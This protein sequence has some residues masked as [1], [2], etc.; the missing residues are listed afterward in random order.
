LA[1]FRSGVG[2]YVAALVGGLAARGHAVTVVVPEG[3]E[4]DVPGVAVRTVARSAID[5]TPRGK[6]SI[7]RAFAAFVR[8]RAGEFDVAHFADAREA[9]ALGRPSLPVTAAVHDT[10]ALDWDR[11][12][13]P[14]HLFAD[15]TAR[16]LYFRAL[17]AVER[18]TYRRFDLVAANS[19]HVARAL[20]QGYGLSAG[21]VRVV[22]LGLPP[23]APVAAE[24]VAGA[25]SVLFVGGNFHRKGL[26]T[27]L[28]AAARLRGR[29][30]GLRVHVVGKDRH[31][32]RLERRARELGLEGAVV[33]HGWLPNERVRGLMAGA[34]VFAMP[35]VV[36]AFGYV[37]LEAMVAGTPVVATA[38]G[39]AR[40]GIAD[41][42]EALFV[43]P[44]DPGALAAALASIASDPAVAGTLR[45]GGRRAAARFSVDSMVA[46]TETL[47]RDAVVARR[48]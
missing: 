39:G 36:E 4:Q 10:Y 35:S 16:G 25:P 7:A 41:G 15:R 44:G 32:E 45:E 1:A 6:A 30:P 9:W 26:P 33:F 18:R 14:R 22:R 20:V 28:E 3:E 13:F 42:T 8:D 29:F 37:Y 21:R 19:D 43:A 47:L 40:E 2:T 27:L 11:P 5:P 24:E 31:G 17:R 38:E 12:G 23:V 46:G 48:A 34:T